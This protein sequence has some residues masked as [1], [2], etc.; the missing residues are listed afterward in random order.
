MIKFALRRNFI[1]PLQLL[2]FNVLRD[3]ESILINK[4]IDDSVSLIYTPIMFF[5]EFL[6][7]LIIY[8]YQKKYLRKKEMPIQYSKKIELIIGDSTYKPLDSNIKIMIIIFFAGFFDFIQFMI[9]LYTPKFIHVSDSVSL[10]LGGF[11][12][13]FD[14]LFYYYVLRLLIYRHQFFSLIIFCICLLIVIITEFIFQEINIFLSY[15]QF[16][17]FLL[18]IF[19]EQ[20]C[21][22]MVDS[23]EK[24]LF[25]YNSTNPFYT[26]MFEGIFGFT[27]F[28]LYGLYQ[29]PFD[30][31]IIFK[32]KASNSTFTIFIFALILYS[33]LS[34]LK[35]AFRVTTT[36]I[37]T[38]MTT[39]FLDYI[40]NPIYLILF[41]ILEEDFIK[42][43][44]RDYAYFIINLILSIIISFFGCVYNEF[45]ILFFCNLEKDTFRQ[46]SERA[47]LNKQI[48]YDM[49][50]IYDE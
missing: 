7:G 41:F 17:C 22:A 6:A 35:N 47:D 31:I 25:E 15:G 18:I 3:I 24:Y 1:F 2:I 11:L 44:K 16:F 20:F 26:L 39:T 42:K 34:G 36:K 33:I 27:M 5:G 10:R 46:I 14:A 29:N 9:Y 30:E 43:G 8:L 19:F 48:I 12:T 32:K 4:F 49:R 28:F 13:I 40:L 38:P 45:I 37:Y 23:N 21:S 50:D